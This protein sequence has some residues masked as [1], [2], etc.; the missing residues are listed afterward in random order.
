[1]FSGINYLWL[2]K[3]SFLFHLNIKRKSSVKQSCKAHNYLYVSFVESFFLKL[4]CLCCPFGNVYYFHY[5]VLCCSCCQF[6]LALCMSNKFLLR[7]MYSL[8]LVFFHRDYALAISVLVFCISKSGRAFF[9]SCKRGK[10]I[11]F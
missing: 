11:S 6:L 10:N 5:F 7:P 9:L 1:M 2:K 3:K 8:S 4:I